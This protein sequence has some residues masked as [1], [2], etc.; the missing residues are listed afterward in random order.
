MKKTLLAIG[1]V[2]ALFSCKKD[3]EVTVLEATDL[4]GTATLAGKITHEDPTS[5][6]DKYLAGAVVTVRVT[7]AALYPNS[8]NAQGTETYSAT[9][10]ANGNYSV[11]VTVNQEGSAVTVSYS[12]VNVT[13][14]DGD[15]HAY[16]KGNWNTTLYAGVRTNNNVQYD[17]DKLTEATNVPVETAIVRGNIKIRHYV[18]QTSGGTIFNLEDVILANHPVKL[19]YDEDPTTFVERVYT[20]TTDAD[21]NY[22]F[23]IDAADDKFNLDDDF[24]VMIAD[25]DAT[26]DTI[27]FD[28][29]IITGEAGVFDDRTNTGSIDGGEIENNRDLTYSFFTVD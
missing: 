4:T 27:M 8:N 5:A 26:Q 9:S 17:K 19:T 3:D 25:Y 28:N 29:T 14:N 20:T 1:I 16:S 18:Q 13:E 12:N 7:N 21:G 11:A 23:T 10:D 2:A 24:E 22:S 15:V 6:D